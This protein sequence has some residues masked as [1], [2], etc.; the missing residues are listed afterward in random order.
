MLFSYSL[1]L[2]IKIRGAYYVLC[3]SLH[4]LYEDKMKSNEKVAVS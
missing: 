3:F 2:F 1:A 4:Q